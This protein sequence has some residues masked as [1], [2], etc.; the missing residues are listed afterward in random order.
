MGRAIVRENDSQEPTSFGDLGKSKA[1]IFS[2]LEQD[3]ARGIQSSL[4]AGLPG[5]YSSKISLWCLGGRASFQ[6]HP[7]VLFLTA[8]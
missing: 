8:L 7:V 2:D 3:I 5:V 6:D 4:L 1:A